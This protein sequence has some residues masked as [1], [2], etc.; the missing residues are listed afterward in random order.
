MP[1]STSPQGIPYPLP[2]EPPNGAAQ[3]MALAEKVDDL[4]TAE[5][6]ER[7]AKDTA[8]DTA[9]KKNTTDI[10]TLFGRVPT[11]KVKWDA[12]TG[13]TSSSGRLTIPHKAGWVPRVVILTAGV[14]TS[15]SKGIGCTYDKD[16]V[17]SDSL[18]A[19]CWNLDTGAPYASAGVTISYILRD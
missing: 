13:T 8:L 1:G 9:V 15:S 4:L 18:V 17:D 6:A 16:T 2:S 12:Y 19:M 5:E 11:A 10:A 14:T 7:V 3:M